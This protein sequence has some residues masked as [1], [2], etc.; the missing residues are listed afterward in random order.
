MSDWF[1]NLVGFEERGPDAVRRELAV[2]ARVYV[3]T[4]RAESFN[5]GS[6]R[7]PLWE[8]CEGEWLQVKV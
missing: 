4:G 5:A 6:W 2:S 1:N 3:A 7:L 8:S